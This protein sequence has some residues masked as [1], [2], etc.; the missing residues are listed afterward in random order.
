MDH[1]SKRH[2]FK[3]ALAAVLVPVQGGLLQLR[4]VALVCSSQ[5]F[6]SLVDSRPCQPPMA[7]LILQVLTSLSFS[8]KRAFA[9]FLVNMCLVLVAALFPPALLTLRPQP[10]DSSPLLWAVLAD[11][12]SRRA[13]L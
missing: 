3:E 1:H 2:R 7:T 8:R 4:L 11:I 10:K 6:S 12:A 13:S 9:V 5:I